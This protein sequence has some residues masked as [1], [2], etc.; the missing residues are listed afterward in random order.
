MMSVYHIF[1]IKLVNYHIT[2]AVF[3]LMYAQANT[4]LA[5]VT[6]SLDGTAIAAVV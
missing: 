6:L 2:I 5:I 4:T 3:I 1:I